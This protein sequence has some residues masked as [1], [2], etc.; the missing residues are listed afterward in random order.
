MPSQPISE[1]Q[2]QK[3]LEET[4]KTKNKFIAMR[5]CLM[6][7]LAF[8]LG[9][10]PSECRLIEISHINFEENK[11]FIPADHN[12]EHQEDFVYMPEF[13]QKKI[14]SYLKHRKIK[15]NWLFPSFRDPSVA[16]TYKVFQFNFN[17]RMQN[18]G[19]LQL[20]Y[21]DKSGMPRYHLNLYSFRKHFGTFVYKKTRCP[22]TTA[23]LLR[24]S[25]KQYKAV[26]SYIFAVKREEREGIMQQLYS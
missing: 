22:Q 11:I 3:L 25:D 2:L 13:I 7:E 6:Y 15:S 18:L 4:S 9:L 8:Y 12:K 5:D 26:W 20:S 21:L 23:L 19:I 14:I 10:R 24:H 17:K 16:P 1:L